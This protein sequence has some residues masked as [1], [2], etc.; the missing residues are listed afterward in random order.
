MPRT[1]FEMAACGA[2]FFA[3]GGCNKARSWLVLRPQ[4]AAFRDR[5]MPDKTDDNGDHRVISFRRNAA[6]KRALGPQNVRQSPV[7]DLRKFEQPPEIDDYRHRMLTNVAAVGFTL[8]LIL[9]ALW[10][11]D[12]LATMRKNQ[13][14]VLSGRRGCSPVEVPVQPRGDVSSPQPR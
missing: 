13:D 1:G 2:G 10:I 3:R 4:L 14:C 6:G 11:A 9:A 7:G 8:L 12:S 5:W